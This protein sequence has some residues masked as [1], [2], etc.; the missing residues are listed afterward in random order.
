MFTFDQ[1]VITVCV[2]KKKLC[3]QE[4]IAVRGCGIDGR[5]SLRER[6]GSEQIFK[7]RPRELKIKCTS[8]INDDS[9][10]IRHTLS[11]YTACRHQKCTSLVWCNVACMRT[12]HLTSLLPPRR[13]LLRTVG[14]C[15]SSRITVPL[16]LPVNGGGGRSFFLNTVFSFR[17]DWGSP[18]VGCEEWLEWGED[19]WHEV[20]LGYV[21]CDAFSA[22]D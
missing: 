1:P 20:S 22:S 7:A 13:S 8:S 15:G 11:L 9:M 16:G 6:S 3:K 10:V 4:F 18:L 12:N 5:K 19:I 2:S 21:C 17:R 14:S